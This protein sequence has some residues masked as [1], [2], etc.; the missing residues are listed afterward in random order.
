MTQERAIVSESY[1]LSGYERGVKTVSFSLGLEA[2]SATFPTY[3]PRAYWGSVDRWP[4]VVFHRATGKTNILNFQKGEEMTY[5]PILD[6]RTLRLSG[7]S[8][9]N[10]VHLRATHGYG[11]L[12]S[13]MSLS[14]SWDTC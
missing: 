3:S 14:D 12:S 4:A 7:T 11:S 8:M 13:L 10:Q 5:T 9:T 6:V 1:L 2:L